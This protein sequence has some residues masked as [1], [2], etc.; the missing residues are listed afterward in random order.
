MSSNI[1]HTLYP[2]QPAASSPYYGSRALADNQRTGSDRSSGASYYGTVGFTGSDGRRV[3]YNVKG[4]VSNF[5]SHLKPQTAHSSK[6]GYAE[7]AHP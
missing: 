7:D 1:L 3:G 2:T 4:Q 6:A 5:L